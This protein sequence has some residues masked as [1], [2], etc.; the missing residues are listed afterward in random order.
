MSCA[1]SAPEARTPL[2]FLLPR[3][4]VPE[5]ASPATVGAKAY[6]MM[7]LAQLGLPVPPGFVLGTEVCRRYF[8]RGGQLAPEDRNL[9]LAGL[10]RLEEATG[11]RFGDERRPLLVSVRSGAA[12]SMPGML[13][14]I[15]NIGLCEHTLHG[16]LRSTGNPHLAQDCYRRLVRDFVAVVHG[17]PDERFDALLARECRREG[18]SS[19]RELDTAALRRIAE[20][21]LQIAAACTGGPFPQ[22]PKDQLERAVEAVLRSWRSEKARLY[23]DINHIGEQAGTAVIVQTMVFGNAGGQ[24]GSG[25]GFTRDPATGTSGLYLD[26]LF[27]AQGEDVV[28][29][30]QAAGDG[31]LLAQRLPEIGAQLRQLC[32]TLEKEFRDVQDF[33]FTIENG[34]LFLL[35]TRTAQRTP[36]A[37]LRIAVDLVREGMIRPA[38]ALDRLSGVPVE[39]LERTRLRTDGDSAPIASAVSAGIGVAAGAIVF[40]PRKAA[41]RARA[42]QHLILVRPAIHTADI[43]GIAAADGVLTASGGRTSHAA[44]VARQLGKV[45]LVN[46]AALRFDSDG[47]GCTIEGTRLAEGEELTLDG[48][49]GNVYRGRIEVIRERPESELAEMAK[50]RHA[51][52]NDD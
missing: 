12:V 7:R 49:S 48:N 29:G 16:L 22:E 26:F 8:A 21:S 28:A 27:N 38:Q 31:A 50:W 14:T 30:R 33:E 3:Q 44:V 52:A 13:E 17:T 20:E 9:L 10:A 24:S 37:A 39:A 43:E 35:Q 34:R 25:V 1:P 18:L 41:Q 45:C 42:G 2:Y 6:G 40:D 32:E 19:E 4:A 36:W 11:R 5:D 23:R 47:S 46:C 51:I 15:L